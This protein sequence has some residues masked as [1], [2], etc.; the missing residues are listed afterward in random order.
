MTRLR[1]TCPRRR[2]LSP[3]IFVHS[4]HNNF[5]INVTTSAGNL[6]IPLKASTLT[7]SGRESKV[8]VTDYT[9]GFNSSLLYSSAEVYYAGV[10]G[11]RDVILL[12]GPED[13]EHEFAL[14]LSGSSHTTSTS[15]SFTS[16]KLI[17]TTTSVVSIRSGTRG[18]FTIHESTTQVILYADKTTAGTF[19]APTIPGDSGDPFRNY[20]QIGTN[21][22]VLLGGPYL[23]RS[24]DI[25]QNTL[26]LTGD[27]VKDVSLF[28][29]APSSV[30]TVTWN[31]KKLNIHRALPQTGGWQS[32]LNYVK[33]SIKVPALSGW[34]YRDSLPELLEKYDDSAWTSA[35]KTTTNVPQKPIYGD[36]R[37]LYGCDYGL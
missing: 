32:N 18:L 13:Q 9:F 14:Q 35:N 23:V 33:P 37:V 10:I 29:L 21:Q 6:Q 5:K 31:G 17:N 11:K 28:V 25:K 30:N 12:F 4:D 34:K 7:I 15:S 19:Y 36:G 27:L 2:Y 3:D 22:S 16:T 24:A 8:I 26:V 20:W 1:R